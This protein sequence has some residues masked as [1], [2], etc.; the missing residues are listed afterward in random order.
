MEQ[1]NKRVYHLKVW[2]RACSYSSGSTTLYRRTK[3]YLFVPNVHHFNP[4]TEI[5]IQFAPKKLMTRSYIDLN[6]MVI[7]YIRGANW[8]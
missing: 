5:S 3:H 8:G 1:L 7:L 6:V 4:I 2:L